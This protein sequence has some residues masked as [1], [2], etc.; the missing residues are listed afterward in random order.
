MATVTSL[1]RVFEYDKTMLTDPDP[2]MKPEDVI[3]FYSSTYPELTN[4]TFKKEIQDF[5]VLYKLKPTIGE[6]G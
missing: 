3:D 4:A 6:N 2:K 1:P 5:Q